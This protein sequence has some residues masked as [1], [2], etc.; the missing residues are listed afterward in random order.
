MGI[1]W[2]NGGGQA[3]A[4]EVLAAMADPP[5]RT[6]VRTMLRILEDKGQLRHS[7]KGR[8]FI[9][10]PTRPRASAGKSAL[11]RVLKVFFDGSL[12]QAV[13]LHLSDP[14]SELSDDEL[15]RLAALIRQMRKKNPQRTV[16]S[17]ILIHR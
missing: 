16:K 12:E 8:E 6:A 9:Y 4:R 17:N 2:G 1:G 13:A 15:K 7:K 10:E 11:G 5:S 14:A 3:S